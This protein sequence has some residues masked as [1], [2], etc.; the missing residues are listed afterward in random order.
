[1]AHRTLGETQSHPTPGMHGKRRLSSASF[2]NLD[3]GEQFVASPEYGRRGSSVT[4]HS[5]SPHSHH[6]STFSAG[7]A[8]LDGAANERLRG[9]TTYDS[10]HNPNLGKKTSLGRSQSL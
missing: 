7:K 10:S 5:F 2:A 9:S 4:P 8:G 6:R 1:M 3:L